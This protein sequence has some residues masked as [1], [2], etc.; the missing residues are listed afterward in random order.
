[1]SVDSHKDGRVG[2]LKP[3]DDPAVDYRSLVRHGYDQCA[4]RY[5]SVRRDEIQPDIAL[6]IDKLDEGAKVL[7]IGC[8]AGVPIAK[9]LAQ[10]FLVTGLDISREMI[11]LSKRNVPGGTFIHA[12]VMEVDLPASEFDAVVSFYTIFHLPREHHKALFQRIHRWLKVG[13][14]LLV[15]VSDENADP[16]TEEFSK[17]PLSGMVT[18]RATKPLRSIILWSLRIRLILNANNLM[19]EA[20]RSPQLLVSNIY[21][22]STFESSSFASTVFQIHRFAE[23]RTTGYQLTH[24]IMYDQMDYHREEYPKETAPRIENSIQSLSDL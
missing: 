2:S 7:D 6:V 1:V 23:Q 13:G 11:R 4:G 20:K 3:A 8:G 24:D 14:Y 10:R 12:D 19:S 18:R 9:A 16:Y 22:N 5:E 21:L 17:L 15:T